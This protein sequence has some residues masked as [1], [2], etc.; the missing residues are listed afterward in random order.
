M[1]LPACIIIA[2]AYMAGRM[3]MNI[4]HLL[5]LL[6]CMI[7]VFIQRSKTDEQ[8]MREEIQENLAVQKNYV[9][10]Q[11][12]CGWLNQIVCRVWKI[13]EPTI[14]GQIKSNVEG[15]IKGLVPASLGITVQFN[16]FYLGARAPW[17]SYI[18]YNHTS[19]ELLR[20]DMGLEVEE[21][22]SNIMLQLEHKSGHKFTIARVYGISFR[23]IMRVEADMG[24][25]E[26]AVTNVRI[27]FLEEPSLDLN[28]QLFC[29]QLP[30]FGSHWLASLTEWTVISKALNGL[31]EEQI[32]NVLTDPNKLDIDLATAKTSRVICQGIL[33]VNLYSCENLPK[34]D[35][36]GSCDPFLKLYVGK[37]KINEKPDSRMVVRTEVFQN[38]MHPAYNRSFWFPVYNFDDETLYIN[39]YDADTIGGGSSL[40]ETELDL[41]EALVPQ[42]EP[43]QSQPSDMDDNKV[44][45]TMNN[46]TLELTHKGKVLAAQTNIGVQFF[47]APAYKTPLDE[48]EEML[49]ELLDKTNAT[50][51]DASTPVETS[52]TEVVEEPIE[53][54]QTGL[55]RVFVHSYKGIRSSRGTSK[56][57][58]PF[59]VANLE[60]PKP[61][62]DKTDYKPTPDQR[63][64]SPMYKK[65]DM[66]NVNFIYEAIVLQRDTATLRLDFKSISEST[67]Y[68]CLYI[69]LGTEMKTANKIREKTYRL[70][71]TDTGEVVLSL[72]FVNMDIGD[73]VHQS[74]AS[75][76]SVS[77]KILNDL[78]PKIKAG[79]SLNDKL[80]MLNLSIHQAKDLKAADFNGKSDPFV[81][82]YI[83]KIKVVQTATKLETLSP[84]WDERFKIPLP[85]LNG[86]TLDFVVCDWDA[87]GNNDTIGT[88]SLPLD[89]GVLVPD[90]FDRMSFGPTWMDVYYKGKVFGSLQMSCY[91]EEPGMD[92]KKRVVRTPGQTPGQT[93]VSG[94]SP[95]AA[96][97]PSEMSAIN[98]GKL[99]L[100]ILDATGLPDKDY[101]PYVRIKVDDVTISKSA[102]VSPGNHVMFRHADVVALARPAEG[103][104]INIKISHAAKTLQLISGAKISHASY[105]MDKDLTL[106]DF[107]PTSAV[108]VGGKET[109]ETVAELMANDNAKD[110]CHT[111]G[112]LV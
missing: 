48:K 32:N 65:A 99:R 19:P 15:I 13:L 1:F 102:P 57:V 83:K 9:R 34:V 85:W 24:G 73:D 89:G 33:L 10:D 91:F 46:L 86:V 2:L 70:P 110:L 52:E 74:S 28:L 37:L 49:R 111:T 40:G 23:G 66:D 20:L 5:V 100:E 72:D 55:L 18:K 98:W 7:G 12:N 41:N 35:T 79:T 60:Q 31:I 87:V 44:L 4:Y 77:G 36:F 64:N 8:S 78:L 42:L 3:D 112:S 63:K 61:A 94:L 17:I 75:K 101:I 71:T 103:V 96:P 58:F 53:L 51:N 76:G 109:V 45:T 14:S 26:Q 104:T 56:G 93:P 38:E 47:K 81:K 88:F 80:G 29:V 90:E 62:D 68:G 39:A 16:D 43:G 92:Y 108:P 105:V 106:S 54:W 21:P 107:L 67:N 82:V 50:K 97:R 27:G 25:T 59:I 69:H 11:E 30:L 84:V 6:G 22:E 95:L